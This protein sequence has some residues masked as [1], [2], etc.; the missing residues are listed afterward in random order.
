MATYCSLP[1]LL[2]RTHLPRQLPSSTLTNP[3]WRGSAP[4]PSHP[5]PCFGT[6]LPASRCARRSW[7]TS[8][9]AIV[10]PSRPEVPVNAV[11]HVGSGFA[12]LTNDRLTYALIR[13]PM[14]SYA[15]DLSDRNVVPML[16]ALFVAWGRGVEVLLGNDAG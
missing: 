13:P 4:W 8:P 16:L 15:E 1:M 7:T 10:G 14:T 3:T 6:R 9:P 11:G 5:R 2:G 12:K